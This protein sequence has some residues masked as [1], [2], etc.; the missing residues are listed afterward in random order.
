LRDHGTGKGEINV[1]YN[2]ENCGLKIHDQMCSLYTTARKTNRWL[3]R[4]C[5]G[6]IVSAALNAFVI[7]IENVPTFGERKEEK[8]QKFLK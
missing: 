1:F 5:Y 6:I 3:M 8:R 4:I 7:F 2:Q